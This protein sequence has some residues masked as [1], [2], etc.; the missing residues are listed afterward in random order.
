MK[1]KKQC[2]VCLKDVTKTYELG[3]VKVHALRGVSIEIAAG[4]F[5]ILVGPSGSGKST[6][7]NISGALDH[8]TTGK[9]L[10][11]GH[12]IS[13]YDSWQL[14]ML[15][16][17]KMG[18]IFQSFNLIPTLTALENVLIPTQPLPQPDEFFMDRA[19]SLLKM[20]GLGDRM[21]HKPAELSGGERQRVSIARSLINNP[22]LI[23]ADEPT[24]NLDSVTGKSIIEMMRKLN[25]EEGKTF[26]IVTHDLG[27][28]KYASKTFRLKDGLIEER[29][30]K[31]KR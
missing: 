5:V 12:D 24:G 27:L 25:K 14:A 17:K 4:D 22:E 9:V 21:D 11:D 26:V 1:D 6:L 30:H 3:H 29:T 16:R 8:P 13:F 7:L 23:Y 31:K 20:I 10:I 2:F 15:R 19:V 18:F 28:L